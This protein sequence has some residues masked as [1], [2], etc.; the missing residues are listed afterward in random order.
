[1]LM[2]M[3][4][5]LAFA[6]NT[7]GPVLL[8]TSRMDELSESEEA[9]GII[10]MGTAGERV[11]ESGN[12]LLTVYRGGSSEDEASVL[13]N[14]IDV[15]AAIKEDHD[16]LEDGT[17]YYDLGG[18]VM[19]RNAY[20]DARESVDNY[21][22]NL[23][24]IKDELKNNK[25]KSDGEAPESELAKI[26]EEQTGEETRAIASDGELLSESD[27]LTE[28]FESYGGA[29]IT[30]EEYQANAAEL[31]KDVSDN[32][33]DYIAVSSSTL[34]TFAPGETEKQ[35]EI[36]IMSDREAEDDEIFTLLLSAPMGAELGD[37]KT[38]NLTIEDD[39]EAEPA[40]MGF[41]SDILKV[42]NGK[43]KIIRS[44][45]DY[46]LVSADMVLENGESTTVYIKPYETEAE[47]ELDITGSGEQIITLE[48]F[49][50]CE[51]GDITSCKVLFGE[52]SKG[53]TL[54]EIRNASGL[55][56]LKVQKN[57]TA[58]AADVYSD[59]SSFSLDNV[60]N[61]LTA[62]N[63][64]YKLR[65]DYVPGQ[66]DAYGH[67]YGKIMDPS[68]VPEVYVGNYYFPDGFITG[69]FSGDKHYHQ[70]SDWHKDGA[71]DSP[72]GYINLEYYDWRTWYNG[73]SYTILP[74]VNHEIYAY[75]A[76]DRNNKPYWNYSPGSANGLFEIY[77]NNM[78]VTQRVYKAAYFDRTRTALTALDG[79]MPQRM[80]G[81]INVY[82][83]DENG[84]N[85]PDPIIHLYGIAAM[86]RKFNVNLEAS[87]TMK[88][89]NGND[90]V[91]KVPCN[92]T[93]GVG[94]ELRYYDQTLA[95]EGTSATDDATMPGELIGYKVTTNHLDET[96]KT[97]VFYYMANERK[98]W[99]AQNISVSE[100]SVP[101]DD[102]HYGPDMTNIHFDDNFVSIVDSHLRG[103]TGSGLNWKTDLSFKPLYDYKDIVVQINSS[104]DGTMEGYPPGEYN[105][106]HAGDVLSLLGIPA[107]QSKVFAG[108]RIE[109]RATN[110]VNEEKLIDQTKWSDNQS[111]LSLTLGQNGCRYYVLTPV[112]K[113][114]QGNYISF[115]P[116]EN[117]GNLSVM[118]VLS[119]EQID[120]INA[121]YPKYQLDRNQ[122]IYICDPSAE[123]STE[124]ERL[125]NMI[126]AVPGKI[127]R[128][129][130]VGKENSDGTY[131]A[132]V[133]ENEYNFS[134][135]PV[136]G[137]TTY[138]VA[139][140]ELV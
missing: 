110:N 52:N 111:A 138:V 43:V 81:Q 57:G 104:A 116:G 79:N 5:S 56:E 95:I 73:K 33:A 118:N 74:N 140:N 84:N 115:A 76:V 59:A 83:S 44:G 139:S 31:N 127:Y 119:P 53:M 97:S 29:E 132:P 24:E 121:A 69:Q 32:L 107:D 103:I 92:P 135:T 71:Y 88:F 39:E 82:A 8:P 80:Y 137:Y 40:Y 19:E 89:K 100:S 37:L 47:V 34:I 75:Y 10:Y 4:P 128:I 61:N 124:A 6:Q 58:Q 35:I 26:K 50:G 93:L 16:I 112:F 133:Y 72:D 30:P 129:Q 106:L 96:G 28:M 18:T 64:A 126:S 63:P 122:L 123:G 98:P 20:Y 2:T 62:N 70:Y 45:A 136:S 25:E 114:K 134:I 120:T 94:H 78:G 48:N 51:A 7:D 14:T 86:F 36:E 109:A 27:F 55:P 49:K 23:N 68:Y 46:S 21:I 12:Y 85:T 113:E 22:E 108:V 117:S 42:K 11:S 13:L 105:D 60:T 87:G 66:Y 15:S 38:A 102:I 65:V 101:S 41:E 99:E 125:V 54:R 131:W 17:E 77:N 91:D 130:A 1:M 9:N 3:I 67:L 90:T